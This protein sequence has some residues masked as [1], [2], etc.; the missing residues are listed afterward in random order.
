MHA[1]P[2]EWFKALAPVLLTLALGYAGAMLGRWLQLPVPALLGSA[3]FI[4]L[5]AFSPLPLQIPNRLRN[6]GFA[7][8]GCSMGSGISPDLLALL[9]SWPLS[10]FGLTLTVILMM[11][12]C[13]QLLKRCFAMDTPTA[14]LASTPGGLSMVVALSEAVRADLRAVLVLQSVRLMLVMAVLPLVITSLD[15]HAQ[16]AGALRMAVLS[17]LWALLLPLAAMLLGLLLERL[18]VPAAYLLAGL[19][20]SGFGH[21]SGSLHGNLPLPLV[22][23]GFVII[24]CLV[25]CRLKG[26]A[27]RSCS[28][29]PWRHC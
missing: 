17:P 11:L 5:L 28:I 20:L 29:L 26:C 23:F 4:S 27:G 2:P 12:L 3:L 14:L 9:A 8:L 15:A 25:G 19:C 22:N 6:A 21:V 16:T 1:N 7:I 18:K 10:L 24:G 13:T